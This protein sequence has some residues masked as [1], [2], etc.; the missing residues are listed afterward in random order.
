MQVERKKQD[1][2]NMGII[3][4]HHA[5]LRAS[6]KLITNLQS[7]AE[8]TAKER[9]AAARDENMRIKEAV[10]AAREEER[11]HYSALLAQQRKAISAKELV[12]RSLTTRAIEAEKLYEQTRVDANRSARRS[13]ELE[14][15]LDSTTK[16]L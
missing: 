16:L 4:D 11:Q 15:S 8:T 13:K 5:Q 10:Q 2:D 9:L 12:I 14:A 1:K 3:A 6:N 7:D